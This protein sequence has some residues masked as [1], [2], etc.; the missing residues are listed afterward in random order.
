[1]KPADMVDA[2]R[3]LSP[4]LVIAEVHQAAGELQRALEHLMSE[5]PVPV[6][7]VAKTAGERQAAI[8]LMGQGALDVVQ[9]PQHVTPAFLSALERQAQLLASVRVVKHVKG[10]RRRSSSTR[11]PKPS[12]PVVAIACSLGGPK[13][14][15]EVLAGLGPSFAAPVLVCQHIS[16]GFADELARWLAAETGRTVVAGADGDR[17]IAGKVYIAP[18]GAHLTVEAPGV[19]RLE[20]GAAVG[21]FKPSCDVML[22]SVA[23]AFGARAVGVVLTGM[24]R[25]G[26]RGL[27]EIRA[28]GG[29][30]VVQDEKSCVVFGMPGEA[31]AIDAA[32]VVLPLPQIASQISRWV[33]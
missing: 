27:K 33:R 3:K 9:V 30:T 32:E 28:R 25:D 4:S 13:A 12:F 29:H 23:A 22:K 10:R 15:L 16:S 14:L 31:I 21:G 8:A 1:V 26:A 7:L 20:D 24:G 2:V 19:L 6:L 11:L 18:S 17:L 5:L